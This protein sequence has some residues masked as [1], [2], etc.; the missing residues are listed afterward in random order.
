MRSSS[1]REAAK[2]VIRL[3]QVLDSLRRERFLVTCICDPKGALLWW[4]E[5]GSRIELSTSSYMFFPTLDTDT[6]DPLEGQ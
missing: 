1:G 4:A 5:L 2:T 6:V 3:S